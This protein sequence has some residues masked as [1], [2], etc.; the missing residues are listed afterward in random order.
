MFN[1]ARRS[2]LCS[3]RVLRNTVATTAV[4]HSSSVVVLKNGTVVN[5]D[6][7]FLADVLCEDGKIKAVGLDID[8]PVGAREIDCFG[9][10]VMPG[11]IDPHTHLDMPFMGDVTC[12]DFFT[13]HCAALAGGTTLHVDFALPVD[14]SLMEGYKAWRVKAEKAAMDYCFHMAVPFWNPQVPKDMAE[15]TDK[16]GINSYKFFMAYKGALMVSD[17]EL[18]AGMTQCKAIGAIPMVHAENGDLVELG[19]NRI[20]NMGIT[21]PEGHNLSR[22]PE[23]EA[24]ATNRAIMMAQFINV[25]LYVVH[26][27]S[28]MAMEEVARGRERGVRVVGEPLCTGLAKDQSELWDEDFDRAAMHVMSPPIRKLEL[29]GEAL[30]NALSSGVLTLVG[31]DHAVFNRAQKAKGRGDFRTIPN[32]VNGIEERMHLTW[33][34]C[35]NTGKMTKMDFVRATSAAA[36]Q[37]FNIYPQKGYIGVGSDADICVLNPNAVKTISVE[38]HHS[39]MDT[40]AYEGWKIKGKVETTI[41][42]GKVVWNDDVLTVEQGAGR[43]VKCAPYGS[44][45]EGMER[46]PI[47]AN[48]GSQAACTRVV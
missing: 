8:T 24:E 20:F 12:D 7:A 46:R 5:Q 17:E 15:L 22:P 44:M 40:N 26:V 36:A 19:Q 4:R 21:G 30:A 16:F 28:K 23:L 31:S 47:E 14:G 27:M 41:S 1:L 37:I 32:G 10:Y 6:R 48:P 35:V 43:Y 38:G 18:A 42:R 39:A 29:D 9:K 34:K 2:A 11:G 3:A 13:G 45:F 25:P 33:D